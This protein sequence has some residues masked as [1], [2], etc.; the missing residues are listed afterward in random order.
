MTRCLPRVGSALLVRDEANRILLGKRNKDPH[1]GSWVIPGGKIE[2]FESIVEAAVRELREETGLEVEVQGQF[3]VYEIINPPEEHRLVIYSWGRVTEGT[4]QASDDL[5]EIR[6]FSL[7]ELGSV[8]VTPLVRKVLE[9][10]GLFRGEGS[11]PQQRE[12]MSLFVPVLLAGAQVVP[13][14]RKRSPSVRPRTSRR[15]RRTFVDAP[16]LF[17]VKASG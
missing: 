5:S 12:Q 11:H 9:D 10:A 6:F 7:E 4:L 1:R 2:A 3:R 17:D 15:R 16:L 8:P 13:N 14:K